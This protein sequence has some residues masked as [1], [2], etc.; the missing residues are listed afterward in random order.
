MWRMNV[1][2]NAHSAIWEDYHQQYRCG[3][4]IAEI[5][6]DDER[7]TLCTPKKTSGRAQTQTEKELNHRPNLQLPRPSNINVGPYWGSDHLP[8][9]AS[10]GIGSSPIKTPNEHWK[11]NRNRWEE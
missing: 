4:H 1:F 7:I 10:L 9:I 11:F 3:K 2:L 5:L 8:V 6:L